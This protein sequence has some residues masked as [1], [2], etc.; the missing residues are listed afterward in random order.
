MMGGKCSI[1]KRLTFISA[2]S[3][4]FCASRDMVRSLLHNLEEQHLVYDEAAYYFT[5]YLRLRLR[6]SLFVLR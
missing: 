4:Y 5:V 1:S 6:K 3:A 2:Q